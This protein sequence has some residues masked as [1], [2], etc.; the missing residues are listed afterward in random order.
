MNKYVLSLS[1]LLLASWSQAQQQPKLIVG[2]V[3]DQMRADYITRYWDKLG[4]DGF[5]RLLRDGFNCKNAHFNYIPT[6]TGPGHAS[7][8]T[9]TSPMVH[10]IIANNWYDKQEGTSAYCVS[11]EEANTVGSETE[12]GKMSPHRLLSPGLGDAVRIGTLFRG[13]SI[14]ISIKDR[15]AILP[16]GHAANAAYWFDYETGDFISSNYYRDTLPQWLV[17]TNEKRTVDQYVKS[18]WST[19]LPIGEYTESTQDDTPYERSITGSEKPVFPYELEKAV[20]EQGFKVLAS[21][22]HGNTILRELAEAAIEGEALGTDEYTDLLAVSFSSP[23]MVGHSY[24]PQSI[25]VEDTY[26]RLDLEI[27]ALLKTLDEKVGTGNYA[28]FLTADHAAAQVPQ[29]LNDHKIPANY[30]S[31]SELKKGMQEFLAEEFGLG[32]AL[33]SYSNQQVFLSRAD[34]KEKGMEPEMVIQRLQGFIMEQRGVANV[35]TKTQL[36]APLPPDD[37][38]SLARMGWHP[39]RSGDLVVQYLPGWMSYH[40]GGTTHGTSYTYDTHVPMIFYGPGIKKGESHRYHSI[41]QIA[42]TICLLYDLPLPDT[43]TPKVVEEVFE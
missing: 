35:L 7:I 43:A 12:N 18:G 8:Y 30:L 39:Q 4:D 1:L 40:A 10:G 41:T 5:K 23:D 21:T 33:L 11:D 20:R 34:I 17:N 32:A 15:G 36:T 16:A 2:I 3:V 13:K 19:L 37:F 22:P 24:G 27:A 6:Y 26:L 31:N 42:S 25:E 29:Y 14:G 9:G 38:S 28:L